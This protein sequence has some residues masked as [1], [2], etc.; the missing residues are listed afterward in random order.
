MPFI[1]SLCEQV[2]LLV[3][4]NT[5]NEVLRVISISHFLIGGFVFK[6]L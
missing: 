5:V 2:Y 4:I 1:Q 6:P 3:I